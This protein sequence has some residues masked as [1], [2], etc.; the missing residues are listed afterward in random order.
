MTA[1]VAFTIDGKDVQGEEGQTILQAA[2]LSGIYI[3]HLCAMKGLTPWGSCRVCTVLVN[4]RPQAA[5]TMPITDGMVVESE[6]AE[7]KDLRCSLVEMLFVEGNHYC[8]F[9]E[10]SGNCELQA[11]AYRMGILAPRHP[12]MFPMRKVD[13][14][15]PDVMLDLNRCILCARCVRAS[16]E[17]DGKHVFQFI[18]RGAHKRLGVNA[19]TGCW[20]NESERD[21]QGR[22]GLS[23]RLH[24]QEARG[25]RRACG[26][27]ALRPEPH[28]QRNRIRPSGDQ[29]G[30]TMANKP[31]LA[32][33][34]LAGC[35][36]CHM[37]VL[38]IDERILKLIELIDF[39][40]SPINDIK[41][42]EGRC[43]VGIVEGGCC[44]EENVHVLAALPRALRRA[45]LDWRLRHDGWHPG[46]A[47][48]HPAQG[49]PG[50]GL[51]ERSDGLQS[52]REDSERSR[53]PALARQGLSLPRGG[54]DGLPPAWVPALGGN[55]LAGPGGAADWGSPS[56]CPTNL[57]STTEPG[58][59]D[60]KNARRKL[61]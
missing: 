1:K 35:F 3:P 42:I 11:T 7:L 59:Q 46:P 29:V 55:D 31:K 10:K 25:L 26:P 24:C 21:R 8:M 6:T 15:H 48:Y 12:Y 51:F 49:V 33:V 18:Q 60:S 39:D 56:R 9:C 53:D 5:C 38:D 57:S 50:R 32:T 22:R 58:R 27:A 30:S 41:K 20:R 13:A 28:W 34:S 44:N 54:Q 45:G 4:G 14:S 36:G 2:A 61:R 37:S 17:V 43:A 23:G 47:Q 16:D 40:R 52:A 19:A